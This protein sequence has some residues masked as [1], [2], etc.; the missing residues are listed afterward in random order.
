MT[1]VER[2]VSGAASPAAASAKLGRFHPLRIIVGYFRRAYSLD[3]RSLALFRVA[4]GSIIFGDLIVRAGD[5]T[6]F[7]TDF[8]VLPRAALLDK[9]SPAQRFSIHLMSGSLAFQVVLFLIAGFFA[10]ML[11]FGI[12]TRLAAFAS[13]FMLVSV[14][15]R[16]PEILQGGDVYLRMLAFIAIFLP[17]GALYSVDAALD[18]RS[19]ADKKLSSFRY[20][21]TPALALLAQVSLVYA[22]AAILKTAP[23]WRTQ[24]TA[25]YYALNI[26]QMG[27]PLGHLLL[28]MP[29][30]LPVLTL[31][32]LLLEAVLPLLILSP[33][34]AGPLRLLAAFL[35]CTLHIGI[36]LSIRLGHFPYIACTA[37]VALVPTWFWERKWIR[38][39]WPWIAGE[40]TH[41]AGVRVY[42]D[43]NCAFC[44][45]SVRLLRTLL[46]IPAAELAPAQDSTLR[47]LEMRE[48]RSW[49]V[50]EPDGRHWYKW[51]ALAK[52]VS[53]SPLFSGFTRCMSPEWVARAG[54]RLYDAVEKRRD[55]LSGST[56][57]I[58]P[59]PQPLR[60]SFLVT[61]FALFLIVYI[62][63]WNLS[64]IVRAPLGPMADA[65]GLTF[66]WDQRWDM[67]APSPLT[68]DGW[69]VI[70]GKLR[71][72]RKVNVLRPNQPVSY[73]QP[74]SIADQYKNE[75]WRKYLMNLSLPENTDYRLYYGRY[76]CRS[77]NTGRLSQDPAALISFDIN[78][79]GRQNSI[80]YP[81]RPYTRDLLWHHECF[82]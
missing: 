65:I 33:I 69:Y 75:R 32:T 20:F 14:Q 67:F 49:I 42:F 10:L 19:P 41:G 21:S 64:S 68:Y 53:Y 9:F 18:T 7:Y 71:D 55:W 37:A 26:Q 16:N 66:D 12:R 38:R 23:E 61:I 56:D 28:R 74:A 3:L 29:R 51:R 44:S 81:N 82:K 17:L 73:A 13:W 11:L 45:K 60:T 50:V 5:L 34:F 35:I 77:W 6:A 80:L 59:R 52:L 43:G 27:T 8:G 79:M 72:G 58:K 15:T 2:L 31:G 25:V 47:E 76:F 36:G 4:L 57:W 1:V 54:D 24:H 22:F 70:E 48:H 39:R 46:V 30:L 40:A 63:V 78:F 62:T